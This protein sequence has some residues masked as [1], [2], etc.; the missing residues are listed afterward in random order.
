MEPHFKDTIA[1]NY[2]A[3]VS[4]VGSRY[5]LTDRTFSLGSDGGLKALLKGWKRWDFCG[6][7][8]PEDLRARGF[9]EDGSDNVKD[10]YFRDDGFK[11]WHAIKAYVAV[12]VHEIYDN[13]KS[14]ATD[15]AVQ[16]WYD[17]LKDPERAN[18]PSFP[19][20]ETRD[21]L[22]ESITTIIFNCSA[23]HSAL[24]YSQLPY[25]SF[26]PNRPDALYRPMPAKQ[27]VDITDEYI[28]SALPDILVSQF[29]VSF[30]YLLTTPPSKTDLLSE[31]A[32]TRDVFP[33][34]H[35]LLMKRLKEISAEIKQRND[36]LE[37]EG[38]TPYPWLQPDMI[39]MSI[40]I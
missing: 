14:V 39:N 1:I 4:L 16:A 8:F 15:P 26:I 23:Q 12:V 11:I 32:A 3:R 10:Y 13:N 19:K 35:E 36:A 29:Q 30:T 17:E 24:N 6:R 34:A 5:A 7:S 28:S 22:I 20:P 25:I 21:D 9:T 33:E 27:M 40:A 31:L 38:K 37:K 2:L 18:I